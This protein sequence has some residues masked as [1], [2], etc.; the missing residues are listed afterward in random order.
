MLGPQWQKQS[1]REQNKKAG[2]TIGKL[3]AR[4][5]REP[6]RGD[7]KP[8][9]AAFHG[10]FPLPEREL[11][12]AQPGFT[13]TLESGHGGDHSKDKKGGSCYPYIM[14]E[15]RNPGSSKFSL[16]HPSSSHGCKILR[17]EKKK[18]LGDTKYQQMQRVTE[19]PKEN[20]VFASKCVPY[21]LHVSEVP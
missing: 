11:L 14:L 10:R 18:D 3:K 13:S 21:K 12:E 20:F 16:V 5:F 7:L 15:N 6:S 8:E 19:L 17:G 9:E 2:T 1:E 4:E